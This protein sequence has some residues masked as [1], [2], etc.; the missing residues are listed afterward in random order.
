MN[1]KMNSKLNYNE[2]DKKMM[3]QKGN[4]TFKSKVQN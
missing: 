2:K 3:G 1:I 4:S